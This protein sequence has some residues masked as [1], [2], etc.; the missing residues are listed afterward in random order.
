MKRCPYCAEKIQDAA[1][2]CRYCGR[3]L[4][5]PASETPQGQ[6]PGGNEA[7]PV[8]IGPEPPL[9]LILL[10]GILLLLT[11]Y[12]LSALLALN[13][14]AFAGGAVV[15]QLAVY[16]GIT[17]LA[18][19][20]LNPLK[21]G[22]RRS[23]GVFVLALI[24]LVNWVVI[25]WAG[26]GVARKA[27]P[28]RVA[29]MLAAFGGLVVIV[30]FGIY[31]ALGPAPVAGSVLPTPTRT[32]YP[33]AMPIADAPTLSY[34]WPTATSD[35][36]LSV[37]GCISWNNVTDK[38]TKG[39]PPP[40]YCVYGVIQALLEGGGMPDPDTGKYQPYFYQIAFERNNPRAFLVTVP[41]S[42]NQFF[43]R[44]KI[45]ECVVAHGT[46]LWNGSGT[47]LFMP[48]TGLSYCS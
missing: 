37:P 14:S 9:G 1:I 32:P 26:K 11:I 45:G 3:D 19:Y 40:S 7:K 34:V 38:L 13:G 23:L 15:F 43:F 47:H 30:G 48:A 22:L 24:P 42:S 36:I 18:T 33:T 2:V 20:G 27:Y 25:Y 31:S 12:G 41:P 28:R 35:L 44:L 8:A 10:F 6:M 17:L 5:P 29:S 39:W 46:I 21:R 16:I 4:P